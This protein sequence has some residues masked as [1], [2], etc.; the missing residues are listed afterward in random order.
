[1]CELG[2]KLKA[3]AETHCEQCVEDTNEEAW[4]RALLYLG[5]FSAGACAMKLMVIFNGGI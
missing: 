5:A 2:Y 3:Q 1:M 4:L